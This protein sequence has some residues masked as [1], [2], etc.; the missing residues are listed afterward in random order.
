MISQ[1]GNTERNSAGTRCSSHEK[2]SGSQSQITNKTNQTSVTSKSRKNLRNKIEEI[3]QKYYERELE[4]EIY[5]DEREYQEQIQKV[6]NINKSIAADGQLTEQSVGEMKTVRNKI[7]AKLK[8]K[9]RLNLV[10]KEARDESS[11]HLNANQSLTIQDQLELY[12][13][14]GKVMF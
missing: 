5:V 12:S 8:E 4:I 7:I 13:R 10:E 2:E 1:K 3:K 9:K 11:Q 6:E 14:E